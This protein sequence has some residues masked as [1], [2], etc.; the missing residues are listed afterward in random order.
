[1]PAMRIKTLIIC[2]IFVC[3]AGMTAFSQPGNFE[4]KYQ[5]GNSFCIVKPIKMAFEVKWPARK[6]SAIFFYEEETPKGEV[7]FAESEVSAGN[8]RFI[9]SDN[10][11]DKGFYIGRDRKKIKVSRTRNTVIRAKIN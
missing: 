2:F 9:F 3:P 7:I 8:A 6:D 1:M 4:G 11:L 10:K 5:V